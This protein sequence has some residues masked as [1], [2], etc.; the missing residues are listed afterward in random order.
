M[1]IVKH[2]IK[3]EYIDIILSGEKLWEIR[4][5]DS[6]KHTTEGNVYLE[7]E[8][9]ET[10]EK[11]TFKAIITSSRFLSIWDVKLFFPYYDSI[12]EVI[13]RLEECGINESSKVTYFQIE[14]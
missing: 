8:V 6:E 12:Q 13:I 3:K 14:R 5:F 10:G 7:L 9:I 1:K 4:K 11:Y 2:K